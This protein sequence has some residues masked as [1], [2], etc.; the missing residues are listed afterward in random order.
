MLYLSFYYTYG[1]IDNYY[2]LIQE[3]PWMPIFRISLELGL[4]LNHQDNKGRSMLHHAARWKLTQFLDD[5]I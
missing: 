1:E 4:D 2:R 3:Y 5:L